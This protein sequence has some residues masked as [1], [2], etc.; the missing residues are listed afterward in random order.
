MFPAGRIP[1]P[2]S[3][4]RPPAAAW[5]GWAPPFEHMTVTVRLRG[6]A[7]ALSQHLADLERQS[8]AARG[9]LSREEFEDRFAAEQSDIADVEAFAANHGLAVLDTHRGKRTVELGGTVAALS[10]A[11]QCARS[12]VPGPRGV[13]RAPTG[14]VRVPA[15]LRPTVTA[16]LEG[17]RPY[18]ARQIKEGYSQDHLRWHGR[19]LSS[20]DAGSDR[21]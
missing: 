11:V 12:S 16:V 8:P 7:T 9:H 15:S 1:L 4:S 17:H 2:G 10:R 20:S 3:H 21:R 13:F 18:S 6:P 14:P 19:L 5:F